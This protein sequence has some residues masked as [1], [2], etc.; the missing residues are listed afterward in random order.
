MTPAAGAEDT[1]I[2]LAI[3]VTVNN[4][5]DPLGSIT[6][7]GV[8]AGAALSVGSDSGLKLTGNVLTGSGENG[9]FTA[10]DLLALA[11][12]AVTITPAAHSDAD[13]TLSVTPRRPAASPPR[14]R[15]CR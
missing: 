7:A 10:A 15:A 12:G 9:Q 14:R 8:P 4:P 13:F 2:G 5:F 11:T 6:L 3:V 1:A